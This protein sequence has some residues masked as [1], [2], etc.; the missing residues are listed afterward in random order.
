MK[1]I[2]LAKSIKEDAGVMAFG[3]FDSIHVGHR[4]VIC[5][6]V[7]LAKL[8]GAISSVFF[9]QK[10]HFPALWVAKVPDLHL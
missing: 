4:K 9:V 6:A 10:Q 1:V 5:D 7:R 2:D 3:F 8:N